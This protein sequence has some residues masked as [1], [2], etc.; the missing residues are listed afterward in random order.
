MSEEIK[1]NP[2]EAPTQDAQLAAENILASEQKTITVDLDAD[3]EASK[4]FSVSDV[5]KK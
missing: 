4:E 1:P 2:Q 5:D 3:Y